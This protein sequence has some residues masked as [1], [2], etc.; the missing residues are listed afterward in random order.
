MI[1]YDFNLYSL[2]R[3][4]YDFI[5]FDMI[6]H[7]LVWFNMILY[8][9]YMY[10]T[11]LL[12]LNCVCI[13]WL[14]CWFSRWSMKLYS[15]MTV[16]DGLWINMDQPDLSVPIGVKHCHDGHKKKR[17]RLP[18]SHSQDQFRCSI[19]SRHHVGPLPW[20]SS[21]VRERSHGGAPL[22]R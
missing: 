21:V 10:L 3:L 15:W 11:Y 6:L 5:W 20:W 13:S 14:F 1:W 2:I 16:I 18:P 8:D 22:H 9:L 17:P 12:N 4:F 7:D 19:V